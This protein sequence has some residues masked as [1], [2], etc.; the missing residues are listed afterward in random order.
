MFPMHHCYL[1]QSQT[2]EYIFIFING[3]FVQH[4]HLVSRE[5]MLIA[6]SARFLNF[7]AARSRMKEMDWMG[8]IMQQVYDEDA[9]SCHMLDLSESIIQPHKNL[10]QKGQKKENKTKLT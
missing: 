2:K 4:T 6:F 3:D 10:S 7:L 8:R 1:V 5:S 9:V